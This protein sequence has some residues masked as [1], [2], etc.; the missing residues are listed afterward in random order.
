M[1]KKA[2]SVKDM[3]N[4]ANKEAKVAVARI[5]KWASKMQKTL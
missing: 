3:K 1:N 5:N 2:P 4:S